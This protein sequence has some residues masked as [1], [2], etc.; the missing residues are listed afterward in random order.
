MNESDLHLAKAIVD[1][2]QA[3]EVTPKKT[4]ISR[5]QDK[6]QTFSN[7]RCELTVEQVEPRRTGKVD[8]M[9]ALSADH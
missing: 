9:L 5:M 8:P 2:E 4:P 6:Q 7:S 1:L 3:G